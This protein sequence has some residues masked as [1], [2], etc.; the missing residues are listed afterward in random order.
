MS[1]SRSETWL[2]TAY[3]RRI[4]IPAGVFSFACTFRMALDPFILYFQRHAPKIE[5]H[6]LSRTKGCMT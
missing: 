4:R 1:P 3:T 6:L 5:V 2:A